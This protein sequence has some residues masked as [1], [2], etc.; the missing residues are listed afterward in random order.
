MSKTFRQLLKSFQ[1]KVT[2]SMIL[3]LVLVSFLSNYLVYRFALNQ[4]F[5]NIR[6]Q[7]KML[8]ST[9]ALGINSQRLLEVPLTKEGINTPQWQY[10]TGKLKK[11][12]QYNPRIRYI[13]IMRKTETP[14]I[15]Q[16]VVDTEPESVFVKRR[17]SMPG[18]RYDASRFPQMLKAFDEPSADTKLERDEWGVTL[19]GYAPIF[20]AKGQ[21]VA[22]LGVDVLSEDIY[23]LQEKVHGLGLFV[24]ALG[25]VLSVILGMILG[26]RISGPISQLIQGTREM[27][28]GDLKYQVKVSGQDEIAELSESFNTMARSLYKS[29]R[30]LNNYFYAVVRSLVRILEVRDHYTKGH[31]E[32]VAN[33][34]GRIALRLGFNNETVKVF[35][36][37]TILHDIGKLGIKD[38]ILHKTG[39]LSLEEWEIVR[40]H[41]EIGV[42]ILKPILAND[43]MI[44]VVHQHHERY[45]GSGYPNRLEKD[46]ISIFAAIVSVADAFDAMTTDRAYRKA[47]S[48]DQ[49]IEELKKGKGSQFHPK[50]VDI[51]LDILE[52]KNA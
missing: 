43:E 32:M 25:V 24:L 22:M 46:N 49:A 41:P 51:F 30:R 14:G 37:M 23:H 10:I 17:S 7:L 36:K 8:A 11:I 19:S 5:N 26:R 4:Q 33:Y 45:D 29:Q 21:A 44:S 34:A 40:Q 38:S 9:A 15:W 52:E 13:Y 27:S 31:S 42:K 6:S 28:K 20:D 35:K 2:V 47:L 3:A 48:K 18:D 39:E 12:Q 1:F 16:F 50:I